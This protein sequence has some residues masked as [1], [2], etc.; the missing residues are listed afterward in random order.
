M[1]HRKHTIIWRTWLQYWIIL[2]R[3]I[4]EIKETTSAVQQ[5][6]SSVEGGRAKINQR[7]GLH[8]TFFG[9]ENSGNNMT[10]NTNEKIIQSW[11]TRSDLS[12]PHRHNS[13]SFSTRNW[14]QP[15]KALQNLG[16]PWH[17]HQVPQA[18]ELLC[19]K[20]WHS[21][22]S[23]VPSDCSAFFSASIKDWSPSLNQYYF[24]TPPGF[25]IIRKSLFQRLFQELQIHNHVTRQEDV[26]IN[27]PWGW[28]PMFAN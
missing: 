4:A 19:I 27:H 1:S 2:S 9:Q 12:D 18:E 28:Y 24:M 25:L 6:S 14:F 13:V 15:Y 21:A 5:E 16:T 10:T 20:H 17:S 8:L 22:R 26:S 23:S 3:E 7:T 11:A